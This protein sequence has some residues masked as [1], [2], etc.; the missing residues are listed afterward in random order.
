VT[1]RKDLLTLLTAE[2][3]SVSFIADNLMSR[4]EPFV[5]GLVT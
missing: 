1:L 5:H 2:P 4:V 3:R